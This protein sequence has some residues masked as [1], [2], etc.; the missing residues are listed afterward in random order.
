MPLSGASSTATASVNTE[1]LGTGSAVSVLP[2]Y[3]NIRLWKRLT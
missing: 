1:S 3:V 2:S